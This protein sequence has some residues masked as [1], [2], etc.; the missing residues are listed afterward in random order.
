MGKLFLPGSRKLSHG[1]PTYSYVGTQSENV[2]PFGDHV[3]A[4]EDRR[5]KDGGLPDG[6]VELLNQPWSHL[7][8]IFYISK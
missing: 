8:L 3:A 4:K 2:S 6:I 1:P 7:P 5:R